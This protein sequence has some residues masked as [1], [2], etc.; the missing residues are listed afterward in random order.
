MWGTCWVNGAFSK[1]VIMFA[2]GHSLQSRI[3]HHLLPSSLLSNYDK[4]YFD[5]SYP[6]GWPG[7][8]EVDGSL[9]N[10]GLPLRGHKNWPTPSYEV[11]GS[12]SDLGWSRIFANPVVFISVMG[13]V[14][15][16]RSKH[17][18]LPEGLL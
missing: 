9:Q 14:C 12:I 18:F 7:F 5:A 13:N 10:Y 17:D 6:A 8:I 3:S 15:E 4:A 16:K 2:A 1:F 11:D